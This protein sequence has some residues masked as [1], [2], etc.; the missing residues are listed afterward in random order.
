MM[1]ANDEPMDCSDDDSVFSSNLSI[2]DKAW[3]YLDPNPNIEQLFTEFNDKIF[4]GKLHGV[5]VTWSNRLKKCAGMCE[6]P[7]HYY[8][9]PCTI[10]LSKPLLGQ[11]TRRDLVETLLHEMIHAYIY[12][13]KQKDS[14]EHGPI[15]IAL[16]NLINH[17]TGTK[18]SIRHRFHTAASNLRC[19][20]RQCDRCYRIVKRCMNR[21]PSQREKWLMAHDQICGGTFYKVME[22]PRQ[23]TTRPRTSVCEGED[24]VGRPLKK[25]KC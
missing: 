20:Q 2:V 14:G 24:D 5:T 10:K 8:G 4:G 23:G 18:I 19:H 22:P 1:E 25:T 16:M 3:E 6:H 13:K 15:Y 11:L 9:G 21:A 7:T 17:L 12:R